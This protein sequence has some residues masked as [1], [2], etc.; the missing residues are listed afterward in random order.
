VAFRNKLAASRL[1]P[2]P[3]EKKIEVEDETGLIPDSVKETRQ[4]TRT[5]HACVGLA[6]VGDGRDR[7]R[8]MG[9]RRRRK[10]E[11]EENR[12]QGARSKRR[13]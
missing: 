9:W 5:L 7:G 12:A 6:V 11:K 2:I 8:G 1:S 13:R 4:G 3:G 10:R